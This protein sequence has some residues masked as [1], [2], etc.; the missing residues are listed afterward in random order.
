MAK[1]SHFVMRGCCIRSQD[2]KKQSPFTCLKRRMS[3]S[4]KN[5]DLRITGITTQSRRLLKN[6]FVPLVTSLVKDDHRQSARAL[7]HEN[8]F[9][10]P[11][12][13]V[14]CQYLPPGENQVLVGQTLKG[15]QQQ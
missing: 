15:M 7:N 8:T 2:L 9:F 3:T 14:Q 10:V 1:S 5:K 4:Y 13:Q 12:G 6:T 11:A